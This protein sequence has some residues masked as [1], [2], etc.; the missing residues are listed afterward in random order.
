MEQAKY[1]NKFN[2]VINNNGDEALLTFYQSQPVWEASSAAI[3]GV[4]TN[5]VC[6]LFMSL[7]TAKSLHNVL[8]ECIKDTENKKNVPKE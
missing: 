6:N 3:S 2:L 5:E 4:E 1:V 8:G 7:L